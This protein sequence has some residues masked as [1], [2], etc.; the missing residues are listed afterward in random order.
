[1]AFSGLYQLKTKD[2]VCTVVGPFSNMTGHIFYSPLSHLVISCV[3][4]CGTRLVNKVVFFPMC[5]QKKEKSL[6]SYTK[7]LNFPPEHMKLLCQQQLNPIV[8][9]GFCYGRDENVLEG[10]GAV[11]SVFHPVTDLIFDLW[12]LILLLYS[13]LSLLQLCI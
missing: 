3:S 11:G 10:R 9:L 12:Q 13:P 2:R 8:V 1:M 6:W 7:I 5:T 4:V